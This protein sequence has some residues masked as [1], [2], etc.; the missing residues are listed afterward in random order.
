MLMSA[1]K[2]VLL[3]A[4]VS[5]PIL[6]SYVFTIGC[7]AFWPLLVLPLLINIALH[8]RNPYTIHLNHPVI[9]QP[10]DVIAVCLLSKETFLTGSSFKS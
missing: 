2:Q 5:H 4:L 3:E 10:V 8:T 7:S 9:H 1:G 6:D